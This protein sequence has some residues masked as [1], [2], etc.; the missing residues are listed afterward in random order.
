MI[1]VLIRGQI[2]SVPSVVQFHVA[3]SLLNV[4]N[5]VLK[6]KCPGACFSKVPIINGPGKLSPFTFKIDV[7]IVLHLT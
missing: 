7:S 4:S 1:R 5:K 6:L 2:S 3:H